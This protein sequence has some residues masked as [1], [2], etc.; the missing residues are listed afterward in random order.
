MDDL[1]RYPVFFE[2]GSLRPEQRKAIEKYFRIRRRSGGGDCGP[3][4]RVNGDVYSIAFRSQ[5]DQQKVLKKGEHVVEF[6]DGRLVFTVRGSLAPDTPTSISTQDLTA[7]AKI[8]QSITASTPLLTGE[9]YE[10][11]PDNYLLR[12]LKE[13]PEARAE[14]Q[15]EL[16][17]VACSAQLYPDEGRLLVKSLV[18]PDDT[19]NGRNWKAEVDKV[20]DAY[21][22]HY[23]VEPHKVKALLQSCSSGQ[24]TDEVKVYSED[25]LAVV[26]GKHDQVIARLK[27][28]E[29]S[30]V[31]HRRSGA[32]HWKTILRLGE[33]KCRL[34]WDEIGR[35]LGK[36]FPGVK[37]TQG[38]AGEAVVTTGGNL[39]C[40]KLLHAVGPSAGRAG[41]RERSL[42]VKTVQSA[43]KLAELMEFTS[44]AMPCISSGI[45]GVPLAVCSEAIV[46]AVKSV[47]ARVL[48]EQVH[49]FEQ[50]RATRTSFLVQIAIHPNDTEA[51]EVFKEYKTHFYQQDQASTTKRIVLLGKT[52][53]GKSSLANTIIGE[54]ELFT[55][56]DTP[57]SGTRK[58]QIETKSVSGRNISLI[59]TPGFFDSNRT[60]QDIKA[61]IM[62][63]ITECAPGPH[64]F[65]IV[66]KVDKFT[67][68]EQDVINKILQYFSEDALRYAVIVFTHGN[69]LAE[70][71]QFK[72][73]SVRTK[74]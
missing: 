50:T 26:V 64:A 57:N 24:T 18:Q 34:L 28:V 60:E 7:P 12:Y 27:D 71:R 51:S 70:G 59:D 68:Q 58:C 73:L 54:E 35:G 8:T 20:F 55:T 16:A 42:L 1:H 41:G 9:E 13:C 40:K 36:D 38:D 52:G 25:G 46:T 37:V 19:D 33:A 48:M 67:E 69:Q 32:I 56:N 45:F 6:S 21:L 10:L 22:C 2:C 14:L 17:S 30:T 23:E 11:Q 43:L 74:I 49:A 63:C 72:S 66:L 47:V 39:K 4:R 65:L 15:K 44:I 3:L 31:K 61:E 29:E 53:S 62:S 5:T